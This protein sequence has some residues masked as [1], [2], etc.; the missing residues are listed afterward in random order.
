MTNE[1]DQFL[2]DVDSSEKGARISG[3]GGFGRGHA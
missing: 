3:V 2:A 1:T